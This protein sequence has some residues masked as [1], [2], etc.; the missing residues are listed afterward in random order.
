MA[1]VY[2]TSWKKSQ[3]S[4]MEKFGRRIGSDENDRSFEEGEGPASF[5]EVFSSPKLRRL[6]I[7][8]DTVLMTI[9]PPPLFMR[10]EM[11]V[12]SA[13]PFF[14]ATSE[15]PHLESW[16]GLFGPSQLFG[17][18][19]GKK[20]PRAQSVYRPCGRLRANFPR[21]SGWGL[22]KEETHLPVGWTDSLTWS[23]A[24]EI[25][26]GWKR[27]VFF[28]WE[29]GSILCDFRCFSTGTVEI[30]WCFWGI[31]WCLELHIHMIPQ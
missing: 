29:Y 22:M 16:S 10:T 24:D 17:E 3:A 27:V 21:P 28:T 25:L 2:G 30:F 12:M 18:K 15:T 19:L 5:T 1:A 8:S 11:I 20:F 14:M 9:V 7:A 26:E 23:L 13:V 31:L 6:P 4:V